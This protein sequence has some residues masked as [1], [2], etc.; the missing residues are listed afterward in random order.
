MSAFDKVPPQPLHPV[1][2]P[3]NNTRWMMFAAIVLALLAAA[4]I[5]AG[6][7]DASI[8]APEGTEGPAPEVVVPGTLPE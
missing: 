6:F 2:I 8:V 5:V 4:L 3:K 7:L 1:R